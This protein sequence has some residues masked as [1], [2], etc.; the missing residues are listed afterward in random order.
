MGPNT[1][2]A[3][4]RTALSLDLVAVVLA[5]SG[6]TALTNDELVVRGMDNVSAAN[7]YFTAQHVGEKFADCYGWSMAGRFDGGVRFLTDCTAFIS[8]SLFGS[9][10]IYLSLSMASFKD[11]SGKYSPGMMW[12][13]WKAMV[14]PLIV[15]TG[16]LIT[17]IIRFY[18]CKGVDGGPNALLAAVRWHLYFAG[19]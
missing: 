7:G 2:R 5:V 8:C 14:M 9:F 19:V 13:W 12:G 17:G 10:V 3:C 15:S 1:D 6:C 11:G 4:F 18:N 16:F